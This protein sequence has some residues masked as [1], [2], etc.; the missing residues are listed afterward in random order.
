MKTF[1]FTIFFAVMLLPSPTTLSAKGQW[2]KVADLRGTWQFEI[3][4]N[5]DW[6]EPDFDDSG[7]VKI[8]VPA[9]WEDEGFPGY[10]GFAWYRTHFQLPSGEAQRNL[11]LLLGRVDDA[12][13]T[14]INGHLIGFTGVFPPKP[15]TAYNVFRQY[16][17]P[18]EYLNLSGDNVIAIRVYDQRL[19]GGILEGKVAIF[20]FVNNLQF[21]IPLEGVWKFSI[22][23]RDRRK[24]KGFDDTDW[25]KIIVP[26]R[27][28]FQGYRAYDGYAWY[29][30][31]F[32]VPVAYK[33]QEL[34][35]LLG[36]ID[37]ID[38]TYLNGELIGKTGSMG[39]FGGPR[40]KGDEWLEVRAY[41]IPAQNLL[42]DQ[43]NV[44]AVRVFDGLMD[45][46]IYEGPVGI[47]T[48]ERFAQWQQNRKKGKSIWDYFDAWFKN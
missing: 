7:W 30:K 42:Y 1:C 37:D 38:E 44:I 31:R 24:E 28:E 34:V 35:L 25:K 36:K 4:D 39:G 9:S 11:Y 16:I 46:G 45:G 18:R 6:A 3:G 41:E 17:I 43:E 26:L 21:A 10:D 14:Y 48:R 22:G 40:I 2:V 15:E 23:D 32:Y 5:L 19:A 12:D 29:R 47:V 33:N 13:E 8:F 20:E 27:W